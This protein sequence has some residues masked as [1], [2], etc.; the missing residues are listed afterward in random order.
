MP[1]LVLHLK[2]KYFEEIKAGTKT[3]EYRWLKDFWTKRLKG[4]TYD[5][6]VIV[7]AWKPM[8]DPNN[9][10]YFPW[11]GY[12]KKIVDHPEFDGF[13]VTV[14]VIPLRGEVHA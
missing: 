14:Y 6:V 4:K 2:E 11:N 9:V 7:R 5:R 12:E 1:D 8:S 3:E 13:P 10:L